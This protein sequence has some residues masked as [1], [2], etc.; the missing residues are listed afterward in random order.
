MAFNFLS[1][2][3]HLCRWARHYNQES[4]KLFK[5]HIQ[6]LTADFPDLSHLDIQLLCGLYEIAGASTAKDIVEFLHMDK[7]SVS[8]SIGSLMKLNMLVRRENPLDK[9]SPIIVLTQKSYQ[10]MH[11]LQ[12]QTH[13][14]EKD[15]LQS[16][17]K[18]RRPD[19][20][21]TVFKYMN[22]RLSYVKALG[23]FDYNRFKIQQ[24]KSNISVS[25]PK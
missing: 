9:R 7:A 11:R 21:D 10:L 2:H 16:H 20:F 6:P 22:L 17:A 3:L 23:A 8:R 24:S 25:K 15:F 19:M 5:K 4:D 18:K 13:E 1:Q 12:Q 14:M